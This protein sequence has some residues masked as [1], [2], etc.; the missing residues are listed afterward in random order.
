[1]PKSLVGFCRLLQVRSSVLRASAD[2]PFY[3][4]A[5][6]RSLI[7]NIKGDKKG[8]KGKYG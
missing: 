7:D 4:F 8:I 2:G 6:L 3:F 1:M 5:K